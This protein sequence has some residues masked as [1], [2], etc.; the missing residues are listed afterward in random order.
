MEN[1]KTSLEYYVYAY[2]RDNG[3]PYYIGKGKGNRAWDRNSHTIKPPSDINRVII[4]ES[5]LTNIGALA[6]ERRLIK[7]YGR[8]DIN[9]GILR[10]G[11]DGGDGGDG[12]LVTE[13]EK[14]LR[15]EK[16][17]GRKNEWSY[18]E[19]TV[20]DV[21]YHSVNEAMASLNWTWHMIQVYL[22][23]GDDALLK[24][25]H[26]VLG[27]DGTI[28]RNCGEAAKAYGVTR[29]TINTWST[30]NKNGWSKMSVIE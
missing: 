27:P 20:R 10:N 25:R 8:K 11:S 22:K 9:T 28:Y 5:N 1:K 21:K 16:T 19:I 15:S 13:K 18:R 26:R 12:R 29:V 7:W 14:K 30:N 23:G 3:T 2:L 24:M 17:K 4:I 6:L